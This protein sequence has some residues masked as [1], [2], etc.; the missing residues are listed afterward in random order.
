MSRLVTCTRVPADISF[1]SESE[2]SSLV[3]RTE[4]T[5]RTGNMYTLYRP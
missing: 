2:I 1:Q 4:R 5:T 3:L